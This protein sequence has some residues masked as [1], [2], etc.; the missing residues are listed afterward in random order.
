VA[1]TGESKS[2]KLGEHADQRDL[3]CEL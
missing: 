1:V 3:A 2:I